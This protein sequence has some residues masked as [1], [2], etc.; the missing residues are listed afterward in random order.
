M[1]HVMTYDVVYGSNGNS[2]GPYGSLETAINDAI[3]RLRGCR[4]ENAM[5]IV[6]RVPRVA[7]QADV[8]AT[9]HRDYDANG[10]ERITIM[11]KG[12]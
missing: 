5:R 8:A 6:C 2:V 3:G 12:A 11:K 10:N 7:T 1:M 9:V 4:S